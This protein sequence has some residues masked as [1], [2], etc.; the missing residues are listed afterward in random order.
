LI[1]FFDYDCVLKKKQKKTGLF[2]L[3]HMFSRKHK[4]AI[5]GVAS[6]LQQQVWRAYQQRSG[7]TK[8][9]TNRVEGVQ[10]LGLALPA[11]R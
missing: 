2:F 7:S 1:F 5:R 4:H 8:R 11:A 9:A 6:T 3:R 10:P